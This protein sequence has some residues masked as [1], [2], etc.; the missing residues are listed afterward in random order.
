VGAAERGEH[1]AAGC[2]LDEA[3]LQEVRLVHVLDRVRLLAERAASVPSPTGPP[4]YFSAIERSSSRSSRSSP[5]SS[6]SSSSSASRAIAVVIAPWCRTSATS[7]RGGGC[8]SRRA[9]CRATELRSPR[10]A[11]G[12]I[13][14]PRIRAERATI[15]GELARLVVVEPERHPEAVAQRRR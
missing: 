9:A 12:A 4:P 3:E 1:A 6:T 2:P 8:G 11:S 13:S 5:A 7:R 15:A 10:T 14:T